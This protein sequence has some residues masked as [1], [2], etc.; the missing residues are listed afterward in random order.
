MAKLPEHESCPRKGDY[1]HYGK[2]R[3]NQSTAV[4]IYQ[5]DPDSRQWKMIGRLC[6]QCGAVRLDDWNAWANVT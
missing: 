5:R 2:I 4:A 1:R 6:R 3:R